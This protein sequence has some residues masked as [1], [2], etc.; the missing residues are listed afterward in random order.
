MTYYDPTDSFLLEMKRYFDNNKISIED[1]LA[2]YKIEKVPFLNRYNPS[3][4]SPEQEATRLKK[5]SENLKGRI[6]HPNSMKNLEQNDYWRGKKQPP[7]M[8]D[9]RRQSLIGHTVSDE[10]RKKISAKAKNYKHM[11]G[12]KHSE[13][14]KQKMRESALRRKIK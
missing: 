2:E 6:P 3:D 5:L 11:L 8:I 7:E 12:K 9:K 14:T 4:A 13:E 10:T 1:L